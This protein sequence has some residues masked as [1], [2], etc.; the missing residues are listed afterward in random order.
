MYKVT[1][2]FFDHFVRYSI[3]V[4]AVWYRLSIC[5]AP[6]LVAGVVEYSEISTEG[7]QHHPNNTTPETAIPNPHVQRGDNGY[8]EA[9]QEACVQQ[10]NN[11]D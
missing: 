9:H 6:A 11:I 1:I 3:A 7:R 4:L 10:W 2:I 8:N 5:T